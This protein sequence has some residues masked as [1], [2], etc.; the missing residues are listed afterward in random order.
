MIKSVPPGKDNQRPDLIRVSSAEEIAASYHAYLMDESRFGPGRAEEII[1]PTTEAQVCRILKEMACSRIPVTVSGARTGITSAGVPMGGVLMNMERMNRILDIIREKEGDW[2]VWVEPGVRLC[3][4]HEQVGKK[5]LPLPE[6]KM[7]PFRYDKAVYFY[8]PDPT[9]ET[10]L[11][12]STVATN[13]SGSRT[14]HYGATR[15]FVQALRVA[16][17]NGEILEMERGRCPLAFDGLFHIMDSTGKETVFAPPGYVTPAGKSTCGYFS[18]PDMELID[19]FIGSEGT[20]GVVTAAKLRLVKKPEAILSALSFFPEESQAISFVIEARTNLAPLSLEYFDSHSLD[21]IRDH[22]QEGSRFNPPDHARAAIFWETA[23]SEEKLEDVYEG[24]E[25]IL[26][27]QGSSMDDT[28]AGMD[29]AEWLKLKEFRHA[30]PELINRIVGQRKGGNPNIHK[31]S[32]DMA[33]P[34]HNLAGMMEAYERSLSD[35]GLS[36]VVFGH[37]GENHLHVNILPRNEA[38]VSLGKVIVKTLAKK[39][40]SMGGMIAAEHG[41]GKLKHDLLRIQYGENGMKE[42]A[43]VKKALDPA[44]ILGRGNIFPESLLSTNA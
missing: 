1:F 2:S 33:V 13:A 40:V 32:T 19:L 31:V 4:L 9:E 15:H 6:E 23:Y 17:T 12:G 34:D 35:A 36:Y 25:A 30:I 16:L 18:R 27:N 11:I 28:W 43:R 38:E 44:A 39:V 41:I 8:P 21:L 20:L 37:I 5:S 3:D 22:S 10:A 26:T 7:S 14:F 24:W 29:K 42:M